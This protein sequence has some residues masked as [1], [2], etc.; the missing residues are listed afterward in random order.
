MAL[1]S[2]HRHLRSPVLNRKLRCHN[3]GHWAEIAPIDTGCRAVGACIF[4]IR[5]MPFAVVAKSK[6]CQNTLTYSC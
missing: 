2:I 6:H 1:G 3:T 4:E 5:S